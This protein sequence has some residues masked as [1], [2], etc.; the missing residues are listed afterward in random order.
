MA[1]DITKALSGIGRGPETTGDGRNR[2]LR[3]VPLHMIDTNPRNFYSTEGIDE[4]ADNI[5]LFGLMEPLLVRQEASGRY[6]LIS[7]HRRRLALIKLAE[8]ENYP[9]SMHDP[10]AC[11]VEVGADPLPGIEAG[12]DDE[13]RARQMAEELTLIYSSPKGKITHDYKFFVHELVGDEEGGEI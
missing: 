5:R 8:E 1:F 4:L 3:Y 7:G 9:A 11:M 10:V 2:E 12:S 13:L 6:M